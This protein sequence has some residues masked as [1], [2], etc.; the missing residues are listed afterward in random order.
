M[1][2]QIPAVGLDDR[3]NDLPTAFARNFAEPLRQFLSRDGEDAVAFA[4]RRT[5]ETVRIVEPH[6]IRLRRTAGALRSAV[7]HF[8]K[9]PPRG[10]CGM[11]DDHH[12]MR[13]PSKVA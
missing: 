2:Q 9:I 6:F 8:H 1:L 5:V 11:G 7:E 13:P 4:K 12:R 3:P 10:A